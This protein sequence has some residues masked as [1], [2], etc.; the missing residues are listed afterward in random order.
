MLSAHT[1]DVIRVCFAGAL[2]VMQG[3]SH[4]YSTSRKTVWSLR[5]SWM[6][7]TFTMVAALMVIIWNL[8]DL[9]DSRDQKTQSQF[10]QDV[11]ESN[12]FWVLIVLFCIAFSR[13]ESLWTVLVIY[14]EATRVFRSM[15]VVLGERDWHRDE[16]L[17]H[18][19]ARLCIS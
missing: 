13:G 1:W 16:L 6:A 11:L 17:E 2:A 10:R 12:S 19:S 14:G 9:G 18:V 7:H 15:P 4:G 3:A 8:V 5:C